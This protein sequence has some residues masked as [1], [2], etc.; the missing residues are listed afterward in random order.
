MMDGMSGFGFNKA[1]TLVIGYLEL[2]GVLGLLTGIISNEV[3]NAS[4]IFLFPF[5][6]GAL[7]VHFAHR[8]YHDYYEALIVTVLSVVLLATDKSFK[9]VL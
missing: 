2:L 3:K 1:W 7:M 4:V 9:I 5:G 8:D 6:V